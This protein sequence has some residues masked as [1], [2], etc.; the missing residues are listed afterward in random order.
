MTDMRVITVSIPKE[1][2][3]RLVEIAQWERRRI[4]DQAS[5]LLTQALD[6][7]AQV[8]RSRP[9]PLDPKC[10]RYQGH[11]G[12]HMYGAESGSAS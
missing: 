1:D 12:I 4:R 10:Y 2:Y 8:N 6:S 9:C 3:E 11:T 5:I 7:T